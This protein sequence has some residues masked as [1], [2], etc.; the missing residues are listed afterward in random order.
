[1]IHGKSPALQA[2]STVVPRTCHRYYVEIYRGSYDAAVI[3]VGMI[4]GQLTAPRHRKQADVA[5]GT[6][7]LTELTDSLSIAAA[8]CLK[9]DPGVKPFEATVA[10]A[11]AYMHQNIVVFH[12]NIPFDCFIVHSVHF[13]HSVHYFIIIAAAFQDIIVNT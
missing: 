7:D 2:H 12:G 1:M 10:S 9:P 11:A 13:V 5:L 6:E 8:L 3:V 4:T